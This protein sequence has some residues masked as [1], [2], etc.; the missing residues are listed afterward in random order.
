MMDEIHARN[1]RMIRG[2]N[3]RS[4]ELARSGDRPSQS[5]GV[6]AYFVDAEPRV[7]SQPRCCDKERT[8]SSISSTTIPALFAAFS[9]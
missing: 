5:L 2:G 7:M 3:L 6:V 8:V 1:W 4:S 9:M